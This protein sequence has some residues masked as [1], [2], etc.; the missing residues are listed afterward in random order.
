MTYS[1]YT[2]A[3][4]ATG[5][6]QLE[7]FGVLLLRMPW[8]GLFYLRGAL[9]IS[10]LPLFKGFISEWLTFQAL[11]LGVGSTPGLVRIDLTRQ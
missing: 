6:R 11:L 5:S 2:A 10:G 1:A 8:T 9:S 7:H 3:V 4:M